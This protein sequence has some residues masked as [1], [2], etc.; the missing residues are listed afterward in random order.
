MFDRDSRY[1][2]L[3]LKALT[4]AQGRSVSYVAR[5]IIPDNPRL[6]AQV[7]VQSGDRIDILAHR[8]YGE[9]RLYWRIAD[10]NP[11]PAPDRLADTAGR[12]LFVTQIEPE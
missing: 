11:D 12:R 9:P 1:A 3:P 10:A 5:R 6:V 8:V 2:K 7:K 4:D